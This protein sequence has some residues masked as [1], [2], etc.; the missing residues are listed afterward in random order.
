MR[1]I[2]YLTVVYSSEH[3]DFEKIS[4]APFVDGVTAVAAYDAI[5]LA[6]I[7]EA[8]FSK[9]LEAHFSKIVVAKDEDAV[10]DAIA[11]TGAASRE[12]YREAL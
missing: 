3:P 8:H 10:R 11:E 6:E 1:K 7:L 4:A 5:E 2:K 12:F 9:I